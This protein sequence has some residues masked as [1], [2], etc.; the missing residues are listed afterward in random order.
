VV[1][2]FEM[3]TSKNMLSLNHKTHCLGNDRETKDPSR[4]VFHVKSIMRT[5]QARRKREAHI[6]LI[7]AEGSTS[8]RSHKE[9]TGRR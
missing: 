1:K 3:I 9:E 2:D 4:E 7:E 6:D 8:K 5:T